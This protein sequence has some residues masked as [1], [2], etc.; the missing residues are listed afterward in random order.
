MLSVLALSLLNA[1]SVCVGS[2]L[3][4]TLTGALTLGQSIMGAAGGGADPPQ[5]S[6]AGE[7]GGRLTPKLFL[8]TIFG[9]G[10]SL[11]LL[12]N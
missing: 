11:C 5:P 8:E 2:P 4:L 1:M 12:L 9:A 3:L 6:R 7:M 10:S